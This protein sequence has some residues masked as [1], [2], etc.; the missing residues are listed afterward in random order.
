MASFIGGK[1]IQQIKDQS[2]REKGAF[3]EVDKD[4]SD[5]T[6]QSYEQAKKT[7]AQL[8]MMQQTARSQIGDAARVGLEDQLGGIREQASGRG[9]LYS[10]LRQ[11]GEA[12][13]RAQ[14]GADVARGTAQANRALE[15]QAWGAE[16]QAL[17]NMMQKRQAELALDKLYNQQLLAKAESEA[18]RPGFL[19][20]F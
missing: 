8:P 14:M 16:Q 12:G 5:F 18:S 20:I 13:A 3:K 4:F 6:K 2:D 1:S 10:G 7:R 9:L 19:G 17:Q 15:D 11:A